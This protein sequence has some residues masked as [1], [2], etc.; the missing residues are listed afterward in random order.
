MDIVEILSFVESSYGVKIKEEEFTNIKNV[1]TLAEFIKNHGGTFSNVEIDWKNILNER[2]DIDLPKSAWVGKLIRIITMP[3]FS[4]Y[5]SLQKESQDKISN[6]P[7]IYIG[8]HQSFLDALM[9]NQAIPM[10][11]MNDT[12]YIATVVHFDTPLRRYLADRGNV[13]IVDINKN[14]KETLQ[15]SA[16][17]LREGKNLVIFPEGAENKRW[18]VTRV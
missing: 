8:N 7:A 17:V 12:Y 1:L 9:F 2:I 14:L 5:F 4:L 11:M 16:E 15:V 3:I 6:E 13:L 10:K 18:R